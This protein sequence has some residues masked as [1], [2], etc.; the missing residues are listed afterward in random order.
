MNAGMTVS[1]VAAIAF[2]YNNLGV[3]PDEAPAA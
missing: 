3:Q 1:D 2:L